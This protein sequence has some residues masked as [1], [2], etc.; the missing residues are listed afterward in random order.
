MCAIRAI[1]L[2]AAA[3]MAGHAVMA[4]IIPL[5]PDTPLCAAP[6]LQDVDASAALRD[7]ALLST[8]ACEAENGF[9][10]CASLETAY[11]ESV[12]ASEVT[13]HLRAHA[14][15]D[16]RLPGL[17]GVGSAVMDAQAAWQAY[18]EAQCDLVMAI[19]SPGSGEM[20]SGAYC[21]L[22][23]TVDRIIELREMP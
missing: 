12:M 17:Q 14:A 20:P 6:V 10:I 21:L 18:A 1:A 2:S 23:M 7:C 4:D 22:H 11:W 9:V 16:A 8:R 19:N 13:A 5:P 15:Y 3:L